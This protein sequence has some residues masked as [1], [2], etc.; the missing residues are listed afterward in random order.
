MTPI[1]PV[2]PGTS[3]PETVYAKDQPEY[4]PLPVVRLADGTVLSRWKLSW[5]ERLRVLVSG[6]LYLWQMTFGH[7]LQPVK[8]ATERPEMGAES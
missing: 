4:I 6:D 1:S 3:I 7:P 8:L 5:A 2:I